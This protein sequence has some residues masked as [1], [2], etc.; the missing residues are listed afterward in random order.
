MM[1]SRHE[2]LNKQQKKNK[3][4]K[5][6]KMR[7]EKKSFKSESKLVCTKNMHEVIRVID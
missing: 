1:H 2:L 5:V 4:K 3:N 6:Y 7:E